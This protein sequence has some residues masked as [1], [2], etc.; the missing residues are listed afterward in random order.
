M[1]QT[2]GQRCGFPVP[3]R[4]LHPGSDLS[5]ANHI[6][7]R[8]DR[9]LTR[10]QRPPKPLSHPADLPCIQTSSWHRASLAPTIELG[11][12]IKSP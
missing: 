1:S 3:M 11:A 9:P 4:W 8:A 7:Q 12:N 2:S 6:H 10:S 5:P